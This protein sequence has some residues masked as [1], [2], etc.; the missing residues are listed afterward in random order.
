MK[1]KKKE[2]RGGA[3]GGMGMGGMGMIGS[4]QGVKYANFLPLHPSAMKQHFKK[5]NRIHATEE[6]SHQ[7]L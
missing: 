1:L 7:S 6:P 4:I 3:N 5:E 2:N